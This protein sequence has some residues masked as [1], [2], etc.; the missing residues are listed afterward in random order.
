MKGEADWFAIFLICVFVVL[1]LG[2]ALINKLPGGEKEVASV[3][4][5][6]KT[7]E[8]A[9]KPAET[10]VV[11]SSGRGFATITVENGRTS[12]QA[13]KKVKFS[14]KKKAVKAEASM[15]MD[16]STQISCDVS[17][18]E[19]YVVLPEAGDWEINVYDE[20]G[21]VVDWVQVNAF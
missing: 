18:G 3:K 9:T 2:K 4:T 10:T 5:E 7:S 19:V 17:N 21:L 6:I 11:V 16:S 8:N 1:P 15:S 12:A 20:H 13:G 14:T